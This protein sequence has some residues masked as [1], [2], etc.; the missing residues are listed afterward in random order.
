L[1]ALWTKETLDLSTRWK[2]P[3]PFGQ[4]A[5]IGGQ[6]RRPAGE[7]EV[8][9]LSPRQM[10]VWCRLPRPLP[11]LRAREQGAVETASGMWG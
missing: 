10:Q 6:F 1:S 5:G 8:A 9:A 7:S 3:N 2:S 4:P 11:Y